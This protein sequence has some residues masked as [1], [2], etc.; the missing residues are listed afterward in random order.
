M[1]CGHGGIWFYCGIALCVNTYEQNL[2]T[3]QKF[4]ER[5]SSREDN[6]S[7]QLKDANCHICRQ[8]IAQV[9][10][11]DIST[12]PTHLAEKI[13]KTKSLTDEL[14]DSLGILRVKDFFLNE[15][16]FIIYH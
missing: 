8:H 5:G 7:L 10:Q 1:E 13:D 3:V 15:R 4:I 14:K 2:K 11:L 9:Y 6:R 12:P 16:E